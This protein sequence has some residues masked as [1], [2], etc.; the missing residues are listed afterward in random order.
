MI[1]TFD[2]ETGDEDLTDIPFSPPPAAAQ[3]EDGPVEDDADLGD[4]SD[5]VVEAADAQR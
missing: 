3:D 5:I 1:P 2:D 4:G